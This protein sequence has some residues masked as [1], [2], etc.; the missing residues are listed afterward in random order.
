MFKLLATLRP[1]T[2]L[3]NNSYHRGDFV[4]VVPN[5]HDWGRK[6]VLP[7]TLRV[8]FNINPAKEERLRS[9]AL[10][11][12]VQDGYEKA[13]GLPGGGEPRMVHRN[14][15]R[16]RVLWQDLPAGLKQQI[17]ARDEGIDADTPHLIIG[18]PNRDMTFKQFRE[19]IH[20]R[21]ENKTEE[22]NGTELD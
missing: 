18:G 3:A 14:R 19:F 11:D 2:R 8:E 16:W 13:I 9:Y 6:S 21:V 4:C 1:R 12:L 5:D 15:R 22:E 17:R 7:N 10:P 20:D